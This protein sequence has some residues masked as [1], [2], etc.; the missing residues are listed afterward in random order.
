MPST[1]APLKTVRGEPSYRLASKDVE[2]F[3]TRRGGQLA[4]VTFDCRGRRIRPFSIAPWAEEKRDASWPQII[5]VLRGD[6]FCLPFG[7]NATAY[8][9]EQHP[10]HGETANAKWTFEGRES[11]RG[12][13][14][15]RLSLKTR[16]RPGRVGKKLHLLDGHQAIYCQ[17]QISGVS[18]PMNFGH[19]AM[20]RFPEE[21]GSGLITTSPFV[22]GQVFPGAFEDPAQGGY[23]ILK[24]G[25]E[26]TSLKEVP[27]IS[28]ELTDVSRYPARLGFED[29]LLLASDPEA[30]FSWTAVAFPKE[31]H[32]WFSLKNPRLLASTVFW[33]SNGG[34]HYP[35]WSGRHVGV[36]GLEDVTAYFH[37]GLAESARPNPLSK[38]GI[39]TAMVLNPAEPLSIPYIMGVARIPEGFGAVAEIGPGRDNESVTLKGT[40]KGK[41]AVPLALSFLKDQGG[42]D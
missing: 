41:V 27:M 4:P 17:H 13:H 11:V 25:A 12:R 9:G 18:G 16:I 6:F 38:M 37:Y 36:M 29:L 2:A 21:A 8:R 19:H 34:R 15:L 14:T 39:P 20:L 35:P 1:S 33:M 3:V 24:P 23:S 26:F 22:Y 7:G 30:E 31:R 28:G 42:F 32:A 40:R 5:Q 10:V